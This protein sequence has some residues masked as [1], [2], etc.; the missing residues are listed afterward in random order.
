ML[1][2]FRTAEIEAWLAAEALADPDMVSLFDGLCMRL[3]AL[4]VPLERA[5][6]SWQTLHP[7]FRAE[8][9]LWREDEGAQLLRLEHTPDGLAETYLKSPFRYVMHNGLTELCRRLTGDAL[10]LDFEV[11]QD[12]AEQ[13]FTDYLLTATRFRIATAHYRDGSQTGLMA[14]WT[15]KRAGGFGEDDL[16]ALRQIQTLM[17]VACRTAI[18]QRLTI[19]LGDA[20]LGPT[21]CRKVLDGDIRRGDGT[22][23]DAVIWFSDLRGS[24]RLSN[25]TAPSDYLALINRYYECTAQAV[26]DEG[27]EVLNFIGDGVL[28]I[29]P[30]TENGAGAA[31]ERAEAAVGRALDYQSRLN[32]GP[33]FDFGIGL[34]LG[35][36]T[37]G[38]IGVPSRLSFS[39]IGQNVNQVQRIEKATAV[40][41]HRVLATA[42]FARVAA[43][44]WQ[45][46]GVLD[47]SELGSAVELYS[48]T[49]AGTPSA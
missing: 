28:G 19:N 49:G 15:T 43:G 4:G 22:T 2:Q 30:V 6:L 14:S 25:V 20:Y 17:A 39:T 38:N 47:A 32:V 11:L 48:L 33:P 3:R 46:V 40:F 45:Q 37:F 7:L 10:Q 42:A 21:A 13:G 8:Q 34:T 23:I 31:A 18:Q 26:I 1:H 9:V 27:G 12:F 29:F 36:V 16:N 35:E 41:G 24:T 5:K 44:N